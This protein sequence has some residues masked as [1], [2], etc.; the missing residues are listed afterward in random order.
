MGIPGMYK[1]IGPGD[2]ISLSKLAVETFERTG[3]P[4]R[5]ATDISIW[6]FQ[7]QAA[8]GGSNPATRTLFYRLVRLQSHSIQPIFVFDGPN[9]PTIKRGRRTG[10][11]RGGA[12]STAI[13][14]RLIHLFGFYTHDAPAEAEAECALL[15][16]CGIVDAVLSEDVDTIMFGCTCTLRNWSAEKEKGSSS[17]PP[18]HVTVY[19]SAASTSDAPREARVRQHS[20]QTLNIPN[21]T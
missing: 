12:V 18:T 15:Q 21:L 11:S 9:K 2:S 4:L 14:K 10:G 7:A 16:R 19:D 20:L 17:G 6:Q 5:L 13:A 3:R 8:K 1:E